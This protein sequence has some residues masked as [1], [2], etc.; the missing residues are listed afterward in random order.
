[1]SSTEATVTCQEA[2]QSVQEYLD[3]VL[4][5]RQIERIE[6]HLSSCELCASAYRFEIK[7]R[8]HVKTC[9][10]GS[11]DEERCRE[12]LRQRLRDCCRG[13]S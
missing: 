6:L 1:M 10:G 7:L 12:E 13:D 2:E 9:C 11:D 3:G 5:V 8:Q 4:A